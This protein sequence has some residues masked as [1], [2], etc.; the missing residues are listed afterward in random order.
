MLAAKQCSN[1][2]GKHV[3]ILLVAKKGLQ[4][5]ESRKD[6]R[7]EAKEDFMEGAKQGFQMILVFK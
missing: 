3:F 6:L 4:E 1:E 7:R 5:R 2:R